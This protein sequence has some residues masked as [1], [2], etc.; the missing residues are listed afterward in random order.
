MSSKSKRRPGRPSPLGG[1]LNQ[2]QQQHPDYVRGDSSCDVP[3][4]RGKVD[5]GPGRY[6]GGRAITTMAE[7]GDTFTI[8]V[9]LCCKHFGAPIAELTRLLPNLPGID[10]APYLDLRREEDR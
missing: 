8:Y 7:D 1:Y 9:R 10:G 3:G 2:A 6:G 5:G 4:C